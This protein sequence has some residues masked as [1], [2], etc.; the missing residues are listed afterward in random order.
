METIKNLAKFWI[1]AHGTDCDGF[2]SGSIASFNN[3]KEA[4]NYLDDCVGSSDG[5]MYDITSNICDVF[6]YCQDYNKSFK[7]YKYI[8]EA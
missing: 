8:T 6:D 3:L 4:Q 1:L 7:Y 5:L 2:N